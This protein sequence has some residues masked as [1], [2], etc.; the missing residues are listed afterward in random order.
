MAPP[1][2]HFTSTDNELAYKLYQG[3][4]AQGASLA[5]MDVGE[6]VINYTGSTCPDGASTCLLGAHDGKVTSSEIFEY[7]LNNYEKYQKLIEG[8]IGS[9]LPWVLDDLDPA[10]TFDADV[11]AKVQATIDKLKFTLTT[12]QGLKEGSEEYEEKL[13]LGIFYLAMVPDKVRGCFLMMVANKF[14]PKTPNLLELK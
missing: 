9:P 2:L 5:D 6:G 8:T 13:A 4:L 3:L 11:R 7:A 1:V 14:L 12:L 10:T